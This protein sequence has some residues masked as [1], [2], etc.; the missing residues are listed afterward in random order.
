MKREMEILKRKRG[1]AI[2]S[3]CPKCGSMEYRLRNDEKT[4]CLPD[5]AKRYYEGWA[6]S[7]CGKLYKV[8]LI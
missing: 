5:G 4:E 1:N 6:C 8:E 3:P 7:G 2:K